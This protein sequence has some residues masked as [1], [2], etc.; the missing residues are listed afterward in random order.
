MEAFPAVDTTVAVAPRGLAERR[1]VSEHPRAEFRLLGHLEVGDGNGAH[2]LG[3]PKQRAMLAFLLLHAGEVVTTERLVDAIWGDDPPPSAAAIV[4]GYL[5]KLRTVLEATSATLG[6]RSSGYVFD[7]PGGSLDVAQF[8][9][10]G[11]LGRQALRAG[12]AP[13]GR[14]L[15]A[16]ALALWRGQALDGL[17]GD[18]FVLAERSRLESLRLTVL[19]SRIDADLRLGDA[20]SV[21]DELEAL[22][23]EH[24]LDEGIRGQ[25]MLALYRTGNQA[26]ALSA[27]QAIRRSM[28]EELGLDPS[29]SLQELEG[30]ILRQDPELDVPGAETDVRPT[31]GAPRATSPALRLV[32]AVDAC[33]FVGLATYGVDDADVF[34]GRDRLVAEMAAR[35]GEH[36]F[37][38]VVGPSGSGKSS[39]VRAGLVPA[40]EAGALGATR[41]VRAILRPGAEPMRELD[42]VVFAALDEQQRTSLPAG[43]DPLVAVAAV[44]P[45]GTRLLVIV[46]QFEEVFTSVAD[47]EVRT[48][49]IT[50]LVDASRAGAVAVVLAL[51]ADF[52]GRCAEE[53]ALAERLAA[54]QVL[55]G[56]MRRDEYRSVIEGPAA[57]A[58]LTV[59]PALVERLLDEVEGRPGGLPL[60]STALVELW[61][62]RD[63]RVIRLAALAATGGISGAVGRLAENAYGQLTEAEQASARVVLVRLVGGEG[64]AMAQRRVSLAEFDLST[65]PDAD[66]ALTVLTAARLLTVDRGTVELA[67]E[68]L[69]REWPRLA[70]WLDEDEQGRR[71]RVHLTVAANEWDERGRTVA[72]LYRGARLAAAL[73]WTAGHGAEINDLEGQ[74]LAESQAAGQAE[75]RRQRRTNRRLRLLLVGATVG[76]VVAVAAG[77]VALAQRAQAEQSNALADQERALADQQRSAADAQTVIAQHAADTADAERLG[78]QGLAA[79]DLDVALL[80]AR[81]GD[82]IEDTAATRANLLATLERSPAAIRISRPLDARPQRMYGSRDGRTLVA[83]DNNGDAAVIDAAS[84]AV[85][86]RFQLPADFAALSVADDGRVIELR[87]DPMR[88]TVLDPMA[89]ADVET[90]QYPNGGDGLAWAP[91]LASIARESADGRSITIY[92]AA[93]L[94]ALRVLSVPPGMSLLDVQM[95]DGGTVIAPLVAG[96][97]PPNGAF[98]DQPGTMRI[99]RW[100][101]HDRAP[102]SITDVSTTAPRIETWLGFALAPDD[103]TLLLPNAPRED[104]GTLVDLRG[105]TRLALLGEHSAALMGG[106]FSPDG[107]LVATTGDDAM[108]RLWNTRTGTLLQT[109]PG[110]DGKVWPPV[111]ADLGGQLTLHSASLDGT[112]ITWDV[113]GSR[114]LDV[115]FRAGEG[116]DSA[117]EGPDRNPHVAISSDGRLLAATDIAGVSILDAETHALVHRI[118]LGG[119]AFSVAWSPDGTRLAIGGSGPWMVGLYD[120]RSWELVAPGGGPLVGPA[121]DRAATTGELAANDPAETGRRP[122]TA[123]AV[124]F[125]PDSSQLVAGTDDG[126]LWT[127]DATTG[128]PEGPTRQLGGAI[129]HLAF[130]PRTN[131]LAASV[132]GPRG[133]FASVFAPGARAA[134]YTV[135]V[136]DSFGRPDAL[137]FSPDGS[138]L[139]TG[140]GTGDVRFWDA[141]TGTETGP[142]VHA[143]AG[144]V[145]GLGWTPSGT[146]VVSSGTDGSVRLIDVVTRTIAGVLS[147]VGNDWV[148][149]APSAEGGR[150]DVV[151]ANG[152]GF[153]WSIDPA[154]WA[155]DAC[156]I[157]GRTL[158][159]AEWSQYL[160]TRPYAPACTP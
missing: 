81:Q 154:V 36:G 35:L 72:D 53:P 21:V 97:V 146:T 13:E 22:A 133:G 74:F 25:L 28:A 46:D 62:R 71:L 110:H 159:Q 12:D 95:V 126:F 44:L 2:A 124:A 84:D 10:L 4:Y 106:A 73:E 27:Y 137:A 127:W 105:G 1:G 113:S 82:A 109:L 93:S 11:G 66:R 134:T 32:E 91:D 157:A 15:L 18:G 47:A 78:A 55:V 112:V 103:R 151:Y 67:H 45:A 123:K 16:A 108:I 129:R 131:A 116:T 125:S 128:R 101:P 147:E 121:A 30:A 31:R 52:Y 160:P 80:L 34:F 96:P 94:R 104:E 20:A 158:T 48:A 43:S 150:L 77:V 49:F 120:T 39:A 24:P 76:L 89:G 155:M 29:R 119:G 102:G 88:L 100:G 63:R 152:E 83:Y 117:T 145:L 51:R 69:F 59:D 122:N 148:D 8:E 70:A 40:V 33:P 41:W 90:I 9:R 143:V 132:S 111:L 85:R 98:W 56:P 136:D 149:A 65:N 135:N 144:W 86:Y 23:L 58:G 130:N 118:D 107:T 19:V 26:A 38:G 17:D 140:G 68:A 139:A 87:E 115:P 3:G 60:L 92:D 142:R 114:R 156:A 50:S 141:L 5:R 54:S 75:E 42:R 153:D 57:R 14:R 7:I 37:I 64:E 79:K 6:K 61:E 138:T 99:A